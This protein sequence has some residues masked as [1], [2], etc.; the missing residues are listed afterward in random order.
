[1]DTFS[2]NCVRLNEKENSNRA[3]ECRVCKGKRRKEKKET[4][5]QIEFFEV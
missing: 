5:K 2:C 4:D 3:A 1:M